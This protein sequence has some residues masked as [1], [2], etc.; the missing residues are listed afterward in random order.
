MIFVRVLN[1]PTHIVHHQ[2]RYVCTHE[3][4]Q[5]GS[6]SIRVSGNIYVN[7]ILFMHKV[8]YIPQLLF[9][10]AALLRQSHPCGRQ[11]LPLTS[12]I[13]INHVIP[14]CVASVTLATPASWMPSF[15][16]V[17]SYICVYINTHIL[18][19]ACIYH[20]WHHTCTYVFTYVRTYML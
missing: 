20:L 19:N 18:S 6:H 9:Y 13:T 3:W 17:C 8:A 14:V 10:T 12:T 4:K 7:V 2:A 1:M 11:T 5:T 15:K 16:Y